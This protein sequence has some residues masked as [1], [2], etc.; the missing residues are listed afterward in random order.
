MT[1][2]PTAQAARDTI[3]ALSSGRPPAAIGVIRISGPG[4]GPA[5]EAMAGRRVPPRQAALATL[6]DPAD[7]DRLDQALVLWFPGPDSETGEDVAELQVHGGR[8]VIAAVLDA[9]A[10]FPGLRPAEGGEFTR[11]ALENGKL[12]LTAVEGLAD[13]IGADTDA[14]RRQALRLMRGLLADKAEGWRKRILSAMAQVEAG[15]DFSDEGDVSGE[16]ARGAILEAGT[17]AAEIAGVLAGARRGELVRDGV[18]I[19]IAGPVNA[20]KSS[21]FNWLA[22][23]E[24]AIVSD[25]PGTTRDVLE[26]ALDLGGYRVSVLDTAGLREAD[27]PVEQEG[28]RR[29]QA[30]AAEADLVLWVEDAACGAAP[31]GTPQRWSIRNKADLLGGEG[32]TGRTGGDFDFVISVQT[33]SGL[34]ELMAALEDEVSRLAGSGEPA[35]VTRMRQREALQR[36]QTALERAARLDPTSED[37]IAEELRMAAQAL[38]Q[39]VGRIDVEDVLDIL[40]RDFCIGK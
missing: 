25:R 1:N 16:T 35:L 3:F 15:L 2:A 26:I 17:L 39:L 5:L 14:Q 8:A 30:R 34:P 11:R 20:G 36:G 31:A 32:R 7:G 27:D 40:F 21:L 9:L 33:G 4:A 24:A 38:D 23:R 29:A 12:D 6:R 10:R 28:I 13:L 22:G 37:L 18:T 19:A